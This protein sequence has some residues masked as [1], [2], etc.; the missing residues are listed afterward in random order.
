MLAK[1]VPLG[2]PG[3]GPEKGGII[4]TPRA[5]QADSMP[6]EAP[7]EVSRDRLPAQ[8]TAPEVDNRR[9]SDDA[10]VPSQGPR[11]GDRVRRLFGSG[12]VMDAFAVAFSIPNLLRRFFAEGAF[13]Q[14]F[15]PVISEYR[16]TRTAEETRELVDRV[17]GTF[18]LA[19]F[20][21]TAVGVLPRR[22]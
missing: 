16:T 20:A 5:S 17:T 2:A 4:R 14:A 6:R 21:I 13:S 9:R 3:R 18:G 22:S 7:T 11:A 8:P 10:A 19:L 15:V 1:W 12:L